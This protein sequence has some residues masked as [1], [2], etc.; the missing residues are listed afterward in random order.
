[1]GIHRQPPVRLS[2]VG[3][4]SQR[5]V[6]RAEGGGIEHR[7]RSR[8][9]SPANPGGNMATQRLLRG[10]G[11]PH[12][13][14][15][16]P[17]DAREREADRVAHALTSSTSHEAVRE[18]G[19]GQ[20]P[21]A[22][23][24][25]HPSAGGSGAPLDESTRA[26][27]ESR[28]NHDLSPIRVH[29]DAAAAQS[30]SELG[31]RAFTVRRDIFFGDGQYAPQSVAGERLLAHELAHA[32]L[33]A[34]GPATI[35]RTCGPAGYP[36]VPKSCVFTDQLPVGPRF[37][38]ET[39]CDDPSPGQKE[40]LQGF[41][42][43]LPPDAKVTVTG[44]A[45]SDGNLDFNRSLACFR[46]FDAG[47]ILS[48]NGANVVSVKAIVPD[49]TSGDTTV[50]GVVVEV[51]GLDV[52]FDPPAPRPKPK[53][54]P[55]QLSGPICGPDMEASL[56]ATLANVRSTFKGMSA[57]DKEDSC[58]QIVSFN[59]FSAG[60]FVNAW[61]IDEFFV[62]DSG[63]LDKPPIHPPCCVPLDPSDVE[64]KNS[65][66]R[67][68]AIAGGCFLAGTVNYVLFGQISTLCNDEFGFSLRDF[69]GRPIG[70]E[71]SDMLIRVAGFKT[72]AFDNP[73][74]PMEWAEAG[75]DGFPSH[76]GTTSNR[77]QCVAKCPWRESA[78]VLTWIWEPH[79]PR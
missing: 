78:H 1:M 67:T 40:L 6:A 13:K 39:N 60:G 54:E 18:S 59:V 76:K 42:K 19:F 70:F 52:P 48:G 66:G 41:A 72:L 14:V 73:G 11:S 50:R 43:R 65:C 27:F 9:S 12:A 29:T 33:H 58:R 57:S 34:D 55:E 28:L 44:M 22:A 75:F 23:A 31:A 36:P 79:R 25:G 62:N 56:D 17:T 74:P 38:Y 46:G 26:R 3:H 15:S 71:K 30:A 21:A 63:W 10:V 69:I 64:A 53:P 61:D 77:P 49:A 47:A 8:Q 51:E 2:R 24:S 20:R 32:V 35:Y 37:Y 45:S 4:F 5:D 68:I 16:Q 7:P